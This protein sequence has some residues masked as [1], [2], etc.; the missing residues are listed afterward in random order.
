MATSISQHGIGH[1]SHGDSSGPLFSICSKAAEDD[2]NTMVERWQKDT[3]GILIFVSSH[4][5]IHISLCLSTFIIDGFILCCIRRIYC[6]GGPGPEAKQSGYL[7]ILPWQHIPG[8]YQS[9]RNA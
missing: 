5:G 7:R 9:K 3:D 2:D 1:R 8:Y 4:F 6:R